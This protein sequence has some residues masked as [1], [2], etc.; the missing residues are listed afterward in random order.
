MNSVSLSALQ[1]AIHRII[2]P[3]AYEGGVP[4]DDDD[5]YVYDNVRSAIA[6]EI[7]KPP[8]GQAV[9][10]FQDQEMKT[11]YFDVSESTVPTA[12][13]KALK[14]HINRLELDGCLMTPVM[15][16]QLNYVD[17]AIFWVADPG[18]LTEHIANILGLEF[19]EED[20]SRGF[21]YLPSWMTRVFS[22]GFRPR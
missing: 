17:A 7:A 12:F 11:F 1:T 13:P 3:E 5:E 2:F 22:F 20:G 6:D 19:V 16:G 4:Y 18:G 9:E 21:G 15:R 8:L 14:A 10:D